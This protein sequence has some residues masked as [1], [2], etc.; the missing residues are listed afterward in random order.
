MQL[1]GRPASSKRVKRLDNQHSRGGAFLFQHVPAPEFRNSECHVRPPLSLVMVPA[2]FSR[3]VGHGRPP[4]G[5]T[6]VKNSDILYASLGLRLEKKVAQRSGTAQSSWSS[7]KPCNHSEAH[8]ITPKLQKLQNGSSDLQTHQCLRQGH[9]C[10]GQS[11]Y[12]TKG[13]R[14]RS[15]ASFFGDPPFRTFSA[16]SRLPEPDWI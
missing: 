1:T 2:L 9:E 16:R 10:G 4:L 5:Q 13:P 7:K 8:T 6:S 14:W 12:T 3:S 11:S 15:L